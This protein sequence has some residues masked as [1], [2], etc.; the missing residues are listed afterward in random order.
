M[1]NWCLQCFECSRTVYNCDRYELKT[2]I[3]IINI[4]RINLFVLQ[5][6]KALWT[7]HTYLSTY[8]MCV[9][10]CVC[11]WAH[12]QWV[13]RCVYF[14]YN[15]CFLGIMDKYIYIHKQITFGTLLHLITPQ[16]PIASEFIGEQSHFIAI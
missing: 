11:I 2:I 15:T 14:V 8:Y 13:L 16:W 1:R 10:V 3:K 4:Y 5:W 12:V 9:C 6:C 7:N